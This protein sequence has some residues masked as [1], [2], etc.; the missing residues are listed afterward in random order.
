MTILRILLESLVLLK[1]QPKLFLP[2]IIVAFLFGAALLLTAQLFLKGPLTQALS[3]NYNFCSE[4]DC[5]TF[6]AETL[7]LLVFISIIII[8]DIFTNA[9]YPAMVRDFF[10]KKK[11]SFRSAF[12]SLKG[13]KIKIFLSIILIELLLWLPFV[14]L[15]EVLIFTN[16]KLFLYLFIVVFLVIYLAL[17]T[18]FYFAYPVLVI[19]ENFFLKMFSEAFRMS[20]GKGSKIIVFSFLPFFISILSFLLAFLAR[21]PGFLLLFILVRFLM[22]LL[23]TYHMV[24]NPSIFLKYS[25]L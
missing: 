20:H 7:L 18:I 10:N 12:G 13:K 6:I 11:I 15:A 24:L 3:P 1:S 9:M 14:L 2:K 17:A 23:Q 25:E 21:D 5:V 19:G 16:N 22:A 8:I 4:L